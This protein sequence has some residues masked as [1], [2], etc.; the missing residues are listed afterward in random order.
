MKKW[1]FISWCACSVTLG[2]ATFTVTTNASSG[3]GSFD[4]AVDS[5]NGGSGNDI[6]FAIPSGPFTISLATPM[7]YNQS[8]TIDGTNS[9]NGFTLNTSTAQ[10]ITSASGVTTTMTNTSGTMKFNVVIAGAADSI[11]TKTGAGTL[12]LSTANTYGGGTYLN[13]G[14]IKLENDAGLGTGT[15]FMADT[16]TLANEDDITVANNWSIDTD[17]SATVTVR[18]A[19]ELTLSGDSASTSGTLVKTGTGVLTLSGTNAHSGGTTISEG[20]IILANDAGLGLGTLTIADGAALRL[21]SGINASNSWS[22]NS[23]GNASVRVGPLDTGTLSGNAANTTGSLTKIGLGALVLSGTNQYSGG[24]TLSVGEISVTNNSGLGSGLLTMANDTRLRLSNGINISNAWSVDS[25]VTAAIS[26]A[27]GITATLSGDGANTTGI[28]RKTGSGTL[29]LSGTNLHSGGTNLNAGQ[30]TLGNNSGLG[31]GTLSMADTTTLSLNDGVYASN[32]ISVTGTGNLNVGGTDTAGLS[33]AIS[34][35]SGTLAKTGTGSLTFAQTGTFSGDMDVTEGSLAVNGVITG[36]VTVLSGSTV[37]GTGTIDNNLTVESGANLTP[38]NS[39]G[40]INVGTLD[41]L[42]GSTTNIELNPSSSSAINV[43]GAANIAGAV[44]VMQNGGFYGAAGSYQIL[45]AGSLTGEFNPIVTGS[46]P[47][48]TFSL[49]YVGNTV[50]LIFANTGIYTFGLTGNIVNFANYLNEY[51]P[52]SLEIDELA[53]LYGQALVDAIN[54][55]SPARN[56]F[57]TFVAT[58]TMFSF[59]HTL[60]EYLSGKRFGSSRKTA[61]PSGKFDTDNTEALLVSNDTVDPKSD[62]KGQYQLWASGFA[63]L[64]RQ[65]AENQNAP[66]DFTSQGVLIGFDCSSISNL[67]LGGALGYA[68]SQIT[69]DSHMGESNIN[70]AVASLY[71]NYLWRNFYAEGVLWGGYNQ[72]KNNRYIAYADVQRNAQSTVN[73]GQIAPHVELG[74]VLESKLTDVEPYISVDYVAIWQSS[75]TENGAGSLNMH[76][77]GQSSSMIQTEV[78]VRYYQEVE[79]S[80]GRFGCKE[81]ASYINRTPF[82]TGDITAAIFGATEFVTLTS[83]TEA[84][85]LGAVSAMLYVQ[86]GKRRDATISIGYQGQFGSEYIFNEVLLRLSKN[87]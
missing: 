59:S 51:A 71:A 81:A 23:G 58:Q 40:T 42:S 72:I 56:V 18:P 73:G 34:A 46:L 44:N 13:G 50:N 14:E 87:F 6:L 66:F 21:N 69:I 17:A 65:E 80:Y 76:V 5:A 20:D 68:N 70:Y 83:F 85:N 49:E 53:G 10:S 79:R 43:T 67:L 12:F 61:Q 38:G 47:N 35:T 28:L 52:S 32:V 7:L 55:V 57:G 9:G 15:L 48:F 29:V 37:K 84:Q 16:T 26:A 36:D 3:A 27:T 86:P 62:S 24:T 39:I 77:D 11:I 8:F 31:T 60:N 25:G 63:D 45:T 82:S 4:E 1:F 78:G 33:G 19:V 64:V 2:A 22:I 54:S 74:V 75:Y 41:L 30:I